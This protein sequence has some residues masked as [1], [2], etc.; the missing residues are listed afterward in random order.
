M[1]RKLPWLLVLVLAGIALAFGLLGASHHWDARASNI[2]LFAAWCAAMATLFVLAL[3]LPLRVSG[4]RYRAMLINLALAAVAIVV[5]CLANVAAFRHDVHLDLSRE[6]TNTPPA[7]LEALV[8]GL[9]SDLSLIYFYNKADGN[10]LKARDLLTVASRQ[11]RY[12]HFSAVDLDK[13]PAKAR[14]FGV[15]AYNTALWLAGDRRVLVEN[16]VD[17]TQMAYAALRALKE[18]AD[19]VCFVTGHGENIPEGPPHFHYSHVETL[20]GHEVPGAGDVLQGEPDGLD[21]LQLALTVLGYS[22]RPI[23]PATLTAIPSDCTVVAEIGPRRAYLP[24]EANLMSDYLAHGGRLVVM[25]D[26]TFPLSEWGDLFRR[27]GVTSDQAV[28]IDP[29]NHYGTDDDKV[30]VAYYQPHPI[31]NGLAMTIFPVARPI[32]VEAPPA[33]V[34]ATIL[35]SSS[36]DSYLRPANPSGIPAAD[37]NTAQ[38]GPA[39]LAVALEGRWPDARTSDDRRF[40]LVVVGDTNFAANS[41]FPYVSNGDF[42]VAIIRWLADDAAR[43]KVKP[44]SFSLEQITLTRDQMRSIFIAVEF[45]LPMS[46]GLLGGIIWWR[47]R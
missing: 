47:R 32:H 30:A 9:K 5:A 31:T 46:V 33:G 35:A 36:K 16:T 18:M 29:L 24:G 7:Q 25:V 15:R 4:S 39:N 37:P 44:P 3:S 10:A 11:N 12:L 45:V 21:R 43:P 1:L 19:V 13:E 23:M 26:P 42:A 20:Q 6:G 27:V 22:M 41:F 28:V 38:R 17:L 40:R 2:L 14:E 34:T 8:R